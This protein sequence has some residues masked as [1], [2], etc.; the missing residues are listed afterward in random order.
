MHLRLFDL[1]LRTTMSASRFSGRRSG[2]FYPLGGVA[3][4]RFDPSIPGG[5]GRLLTFT[6][7][8]AGFGR[9]VGSGDGL[10]VEAVAQRALYLL[11]RSNVNVVHHGE[12]ALEE[13]SKVV[14]ERLFSL[15]KGLV[16]FLHPFD[17]TRGVGQD[18]VCAL[19]SLTHDQLRLPV[20]V[21]AKVS[22]DLLGVYDRRPDRVLKL[23]ELLE[24]TPKIRY[25]LR[26]ALVLREG[27]LELV[28]D[29]VKEIIHLVGVV[30]AYAGLELLA[31]DVRRSYSHRITP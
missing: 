12:V 13:M 27:A 17:P 5:L 3:A 30:A 7:D 20:R 23:L 15:A 22:R 8:S 11:R 2:G 26:E 1:G 21:L 24:A 14:G 4:L 31:P 10:K 25:L 19:I 18:P 29:R 6:L 28:R 16:G 9:F